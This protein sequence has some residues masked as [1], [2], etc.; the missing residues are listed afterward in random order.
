MLIASRVK[1]EIIIVTNEESAGQI[2]IKSGVS[3]AVGEE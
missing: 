1:E 2:S 3:K